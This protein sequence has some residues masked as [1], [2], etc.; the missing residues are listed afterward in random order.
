MI[1]LSVA[2]GSLESQG[3]EVEEVTMEF[4]GENDMRVTK[5]SLRGHGRLPIKLS[6]TCQSVGE[7]SGVAGRSDARKPGACVPDPQSRS[8][9]Q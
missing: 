1:G 6:A 2:A 5:R 9:V 4:D 8:P 3:I 7:V